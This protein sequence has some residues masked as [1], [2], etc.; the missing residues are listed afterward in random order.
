MKLKI[1]ILIFIILSLL[2][3]INNILKNKENF[4]I[5]HTAPLTLIKKDCEKHFSKNFSKKFIDKNRL[6]HRSAF[7]KTPILLS[8]ICGGNN[9]GSDKPLYVLKDRN[10][11]EVYYG[12][13]ETFDKNLNWHYSNDKFPSFESMKLTKKLS[14][15]ITTNFVTKSDLIL[16]IA[17]DNDVTII[18]EDKYLPCSKYSSDYKG[19]NQKCYRYIWEKAGCGTGELGYP[20][21]DA[22]WQKSQTLNGLINDSWLWSTMTDS[23]HRIG[24]YGSKNTNYNKKYNISQKLIDVINSKT[25]DTYKSNNFGIFVIRNF[26]YNKKIVLNIKNT[27]TRK[28]GGIC[29]SYLYNG[30]LYVLNNTKL[31]ESTNKKHSFNSLNYTI[32]ND[33]GFI[34]NNITSYTDKIPELP[35]FM[36]NWL[37]IPSSENGINISFNSGI[38]NNITNSRLTI[39]IIING[40]A[41]IKITNNEPYNY[42]FS[43]KNTLVNFSRGGVNPTDK[44]TIN[45]SSDGVKRNSP[46]LSIAYI[47]KGNLFVLNNSRATGNKIDIINKSNKMGY[48]CIGINN[49][50]VDNINVKTPFFMTGWL[51]SSNNIN[52]LEFTTRIGKGI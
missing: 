27:D 38:K 50:V 9:K 11:N 23:D 51:N 12:C 44:I 5:H 33:K 18:N 26:R 41:S 21:A 13:N 45:I 17:S 46:L 32:S 16:F 15:S 36:N 19:I 40:T 25:I 24:C 2:Y 52:K 7:V 1:F 4:K 31:D 14:N 42:N 48:S 37:N 10:N 20:S 6:C 30:Q 29:F 39:F 3:L 35:T 28:M 47:Y 34:S 43:K 8:G 49:N 22:S